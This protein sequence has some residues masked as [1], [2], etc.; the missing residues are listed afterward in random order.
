MFYSREKEPPATSARSARS[1]GLSDVFT[2]TPARNLFLMT[3]LVP[4]R[5]VQV[6]PGFMIHNKAMAWRPYEN[7][8]DG[9]LDNR[10]PGKVTGW[11]LFYR[12]NKKPLR[13]TFDLAGDFH[14]DIRGKV[15]R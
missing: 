9:E 10:I 1:A 15:I 3:E 2:P 13:A 14:D 11:M 4:S 12:A 5:P 6:E 7:L 8:I